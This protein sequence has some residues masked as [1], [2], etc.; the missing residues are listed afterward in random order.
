MVTS[1]YENLWFGLSL[2][3]IKALQWVLVFSTYCI[4]S[5]RPYEGMAGL[6][7]YLAKFDNNK[8]YVHRPGS[9][10]CVC[11]HSCVYMCLYIFREIYFAQN[12]LQETKTIVK[13]YYNICS[14]KNILCFALNLN[15][16]RV[17][18]CKKKGPA[19]WDC[20]FPN[21]NKS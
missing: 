11:V 21:S 8:S 15:R 19:P 16:I 9:Y 10:V 3:V 18:A 6:S 2:V 14:A 12:S 5:L 4:V 13:G 1:C 17:W 20:C 7:K